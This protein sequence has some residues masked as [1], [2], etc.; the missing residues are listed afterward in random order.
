MVCFTEIS[1][2]WIYSLS[3]FKNEMGHSLFTF[4]HFSFKEEELNIFDHF[5]ILKAM[6]NTLV[7]FLVFF[8]NIYYT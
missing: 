8:Q 4:I 2:V 6:V 3:Y 5:M 7:Y 1:V